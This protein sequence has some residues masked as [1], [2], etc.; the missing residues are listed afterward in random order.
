MYSNH[1]SLG[2]KHLWYLW[3]YYAKHLIMS[4]KL[5]CC[6]SCFFS[7]YHL[8]F[9]FHIPATIYVVRKIRASI[10][11]GEQ[12]EK[13]IITP[14]SAIGKI[15][16]TTNV[17]TSAE[18][19]AMTQNSRTCKIR[20]NPKWRLWRTHCFLLKLYDPCRY[21]SFCRMVSWLVRLQ[22]TAGFY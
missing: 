11:E 10:A 21:F 15:M 12:L 19:T 5:Q 7:L 14:C 4:L 1:L 16:K 13:P 9:L 18:H 2:Q 20:M 8:T 6:F 17:T 22:R 3:K